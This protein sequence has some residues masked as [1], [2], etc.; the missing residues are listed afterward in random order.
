M[1]RTLQT[2]WLKIFLRVNE[3]CWISIE[4]HTLF[5]LLYT[6]PKFSTPMIWSYQ[7]IDDSFRI[8]E[9]GSLSYISLMV[10]WRLISRNALI[11]SKTTTCC[12]IEGLPSNEKLEL[13]CHCLIPFKYIYRKLH[14][15]FCWEK[16]MPHVQI[17]IINLAI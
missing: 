2:R 8:G 5:K 13:I 17:K 4:E 15:F 11:V 12:E 10:A 6:Y 14:H 3:Q 9:G 1:D 16:I 7:P